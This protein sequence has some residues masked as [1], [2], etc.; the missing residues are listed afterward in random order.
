MA[1][2]TTE[3]GPFKVVKITHHPTNERVSTADYL[4]KT[5]NKLHHAGYD[6]ISIVVVE[7]T[8]ATQE[9]LITSKLRSPGS[10]A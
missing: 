10:G 6:V 8:P 3:D 2:S 1:P 5:L 4:Q 9:L 7:R